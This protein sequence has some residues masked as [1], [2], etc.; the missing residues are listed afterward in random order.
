MTRRHCR[1]CRRRFTPARPADRY[2]D[3]CWATRQAGFSPAWLI[4]R[5]RLIE[6]DVL[7]AVARDDERDGA[8]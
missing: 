5:E 2:C 1:A 6:T 4:E 3:R 7:D 8:R